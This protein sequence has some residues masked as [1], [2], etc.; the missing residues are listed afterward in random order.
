[1]AGFHYP[2]GV[3]VLPTIRT[4]FAVAGLFTVAACA[5]AATS[6]P[7]SGPAPGTTA[8]TIE[9]SDL[10]HRIE[11]LA[12]DS[13]AGRETGKPGI[14]LAAEYL[15]AEARRLGLRP[16]GD[17]GTFFQR[18]PLERK[19]THA[20]VTV[21]GPGGSTTLGADE[22][23]P[24]S[25]IGGLPAASRFQG[26]G[27]LIFGGHLVD[28]PLGT[29]ELDLE[30][31][32][33]AVV[34]VRLNPPVGVDANAAPPRLAMATLFSPA[35]PASAV[36]LVA[37]ETEEAFWD[38]AADVSM[39]GAIALESN[40]SSGPTAPPFFLIS[41]EAAERLLGTSLADSR[42][43]RTGLGS[44]QYSIEERVEV[45]E[46][47]NVI[48]ILPGSEPARAGEYV[49]LGAHYDHVG[50][51]IPQNGDSIFNG[52]DDNA[53]GTAALLEV[54]EALAHLPANQRP[55]RSVLFAWVTAEE[56]GLLGSEHFTD[57][58]TVPRESM[59]AHI[60][61]D[62]VGRNS[63][64]SIFSVGSR[65]ISTELGDLVEAVNRRQARP[66]V[67]D[68]EY[69]AP[70]HPEQIYC[71]SDHYNYARF[72]IPILFLT[73]G[74]HDQYHAPTDEAHLIDFDKAARV[75][76]LVRDI[77]LDLANAPM[78]PR[79]DQPVPPLGTPCM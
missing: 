20:T 32:R 73:T 12:S 48:A 57:N 62:M 66:F 34:I 60:N 44:V 69:D 21:N 41:P 76:T 14:D 19:S 11:F 59:V 37:E 63:P 9:A 29:D 18:V 22:I 45:I 52:A 36:F 35:S 17:S 31:L 58:P 61:L 64:D 67:F 33:D 38:Y 5:S 3:F 70:G 79:V 4:Y 7:A 16:G 65:R 27:P 23:L 78:R 46:G 13:L 30:Q 39:K 77:T 25:G 47:R 51:G 40:A 68:F 75:A 71:R 54:A 8:A 1:M 43:P 53:S 6:S 28:E 56:S 50:V 24:V 10:R 49:T 55:A 72:G 15:A 2:T 26:G 42:R 74:L